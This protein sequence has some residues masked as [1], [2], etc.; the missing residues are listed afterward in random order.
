MLGT[1]FADIDLDPIDKS[2]EDRIIDVGPFSKECRILGQF[3][4]KTIDNTLIRQL[5]IIKIPNDK[6]S[7]A[8]IYNLERKL[9]NPSERIT[10]VYYG[11][12][13][14]TSKTK[15]TFREEKLIAKYEE[16]NNTGYV[17]VS[18]TNN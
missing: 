6:K 18:I 12:W 4:D 16:Q 14:D 9:N 11:K 15:Y 5:Q 10:G 17:R 7:P 1:F 3:R 13:L 8:M 2:F